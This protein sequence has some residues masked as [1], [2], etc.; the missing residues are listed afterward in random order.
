MNKTFRRLSPG[1]VAV[2]ALLLTP[3]ASRAQFTASYQTNIID[4]AV[5]NWAGD[6]IVG[7]NAVFDDLQILN[8]GVVSNYTG[9]VGYNSAGGNN[10]ALVSGT[11]SL[12]KSGNALF[13]GYESSVNSLV[14]SNGGMVVGAGQIGFCGSSNSVLVTGTGLVWSNIVDLYLG[15]ALYTGYLSRGNS[16]VIRDGGQV[17]NQ[18]GRLG[19]YYSTNASVLVTGAG[20]VWNNSGTLSVGVQSGGNSLAVDGAGKVLSS[21]GVIGLTSLGVS[22][23]SNT[24]LISDAGS[25]WS[26]QGSLFI[27]RSDG[28]K[29]VPAGSGNSLVI[30]N[31]GMVVVASNMIV[32]S[33]NSVVLNNGNLT[34]GTGLVVSNGAIIKGSGTIYANLTLAGTLAP[35]NS[36]GAL[37]NFG[38]L[39]LQSGAVLQFE[40]G[41]TTQ[42]SGYDF[43][44]VTNGVATLNGLL[45]VGFVNGFQTN[46]LDSDTFTLLAADTLTGSFT[47]V[48]SGQRLTTADG[49]GSFQVDYSGNDLV[50]SGY[51]VIPEPG[52]LALCTIGV[53]VLFASRW[54]VR[55]A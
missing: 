31:G 29:Q 39:T 26:N 22:G 25:V 28:Y 41:G 8:G 32:A 42:G 11:G 33:G 46:V 30:S 49:E 20:L 14:I 48:L 9:V 5:I 35:G 51:Q 36:P 17:F 43:I 7:S 18:Q 23:D 47:N 3:Q 24:V 12:W 34:V 37:T 45:Q 55:R 10:T 4:G 16:L 53:A 54:H 1:L 19:T 27:G 21:S 2:F 44:L 15:S 38:S 40:L 13:V 50:L 52:T 6:Y